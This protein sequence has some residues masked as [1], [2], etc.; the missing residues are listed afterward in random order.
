MPAEF[1]TPFKSDSVKGV[2]RAAG[3]DICLL[4]ISCVLWLF[5]VSLD[6]AS[7]D[8]YQRLAHEQ[9]LACRERKSEQSKEAR[10]KERSLSKE[11]RRRQK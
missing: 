6:P 5:S 2:H 7:R 1:G 8:K 11:T 3:K 9:F 10:S 4:L